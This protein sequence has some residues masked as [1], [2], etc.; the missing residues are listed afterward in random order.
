M[1]E[2]QPDWLKCLAGHKALADDELDL[3][4]L[5][6]GDVLVVV[7]E[8]TRY[9]LR[10][11]D[12]KHAEL[13]TD[14]PDRPRGPARINGCTFGMSSSIKPDSLFCGGN[15]ELSLEDGKIIHNTTAIRYLHLLRRETIP[16]DR[17]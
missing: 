7:T 3:G 11:T 2:M 12:G 17:D 16:A 6:R 10:I 1:S 9:A 8:H 13:E 14:R 15:L 4:L 5:R